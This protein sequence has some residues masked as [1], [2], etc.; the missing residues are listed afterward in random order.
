MFVYQ[1]VTC[2]GFSQDT[3][4]RPSMEKLE[5][6]P[7]VGGRILSDFVLVIIGWWKDK[8]GETIPIISSYPL[9]N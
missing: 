1:R 2:D 7:E 5:N 6:P 9:V 4:I 8:D 3:T